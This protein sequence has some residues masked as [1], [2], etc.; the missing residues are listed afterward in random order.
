MSLFFSQ[1]RLTM[2]FSQNFDMA[3]K[4]EWLIRNEE[5]KDNEIRFDL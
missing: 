4:K 3:Q 1:K 2:P 5:K